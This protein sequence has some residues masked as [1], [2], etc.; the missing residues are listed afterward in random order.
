MNSGKQRAAIEVITQRNLQQKN[1]NMTE[2]INEND[3]VRLNVKRL[4]RGTDWKRM[5]NE[6]KRFVEANQNT[7][8]TAHLESVALVSMK[9]DGRWLFCME[10]VIKHEE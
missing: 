3:K 7:V 6:Y 8:F 1:S 5:T 2:C 4:K 10:D 9:E